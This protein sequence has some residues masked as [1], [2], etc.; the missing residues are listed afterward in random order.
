MIGWKTSVFWLGCNL[1]STVIHAQQ[2]FAQES[3]W[4]LGNWNGKRTALAEQGYTFD[5]GYTGE[6]ASLLD[7][8]YSNNHRTEYADQFALGTHL[9]LEKILGWPDTQAQITLTERNGHSLSDKN[10]GV[11]GD[12]RVGHLSATQEV[13][14]RG[15]TWR[16]T[17]FWIQKQFLDKRLDIKLGRFGE[18]EDFNSFNCDFQ[19]LSLC[20]SQVGNWV[21]DIWYNWPVSQW[22]GRVKYNMQPDW[23]AQVGVY[24]YNPENL[25]RSKGFNLSTDGSKGAIIPIE[26]VWQPKLGLQQ[27]PGEYRAGYYH[28]TAD[29]GRINSSDRTEH[30]HGGW[31][32]LK[33]QLTSKTD[34]GN[35]DSM[36]NNSRGL[37]GFANI[38]L[39]DKDTNTVDNFQNIGLVYHGWFD[40]R[41]R[42]DIGLGFSR[43]HVNDAVSRVQK[44]NDILLNIDDPSYQP[45]QDTEY[46][47]E[48]YY[49]LH[50][51]DWLTL[52]PNI[53]YIKHAGGV[54]YLDDTWVGGIK[55]QL[56]F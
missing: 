31:L 32:V 14:G 25:E 29:S 21:G 28:S 55:L 8:G 45:V 33:Q 51:S 12:P 49:G 54:D 15:Q 43:I 37:T 46:N 19:N 39:H 50:L 35:D 48:L 27:L 2:P 42:D 44:Q 40:Q 41:P 23:Y 1:L 13:W 38:T 36:N 47:A 22:A 16:L 53:Q 9:D 20:G 52:R 26:L 17:D 56:G 18:G 11:I 34:T 4:M 24:E 5:L 6:M 30:K 7:G 3:Q 10:Y